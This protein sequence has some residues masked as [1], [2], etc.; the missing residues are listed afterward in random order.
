MPGRIGTCADPEGV[1][2]AARTPPP[3]NKQNHE[4]LYVSLV[5][6]LYGPLREGSGPLWSNYL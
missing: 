6:Y 5:I 2:Q 3:Q 1:G 4:W